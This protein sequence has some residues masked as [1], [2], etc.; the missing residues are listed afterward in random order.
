LMPSIGSMSTP[1]RMGVLFIDGL[2]ANSAGSGQ[3]GANA[4]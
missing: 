1:R 4:A 3:A 2:R